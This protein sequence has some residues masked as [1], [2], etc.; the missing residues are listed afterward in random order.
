MSQ[1]VFAYGSNMCL[2]R[3]LAYG[4]HPQQ[5]G[6]AARLDG[7]SLRFN[8][9]STD[10]SGK[11]NVEPEAAGSVW[12]VLY[13][14]PDA[15]LPVLAAG[16][17]GYTSIRESTVCGTRSMEAWVYVATRP[18][19]DGTL[20]PYSWYKRFL[21]DGAQSHRLPP[22]YI[23]TLEAVVAAEDPNRNR[24]RKKRALPCEGAR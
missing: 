9:R 4:V 3:F 23:A 16:E 14:I 7:Y 6:E 22:D 5:P 15:D 19:D 21:V 11:A 18:S 20:Q 13:L 1:R 12:G 8:K 2:G 10:G 17:R 24:D